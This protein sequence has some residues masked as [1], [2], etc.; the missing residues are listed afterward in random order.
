[1]SCYIA[2]GESWREN[3]GNLPLEGVPRIVRVYLPADR[4]RVEVQRIEF[5]STNCWSRQMES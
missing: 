3:E 5:R 1:M 4:V 2:G